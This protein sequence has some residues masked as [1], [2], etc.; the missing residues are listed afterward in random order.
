M[1][2]LSWLR[3]EKP[4]HE[5]LAEEGG[6]TTLAPEPE[7]H[8]TRP[9]WGEVGIH[10]VHRPRRWDVVATAEAPDLPGSRLQFV[11]LPDGSL[12]V[13]D[14]VGDADLAP[15]A[16]AVETQLA[17]PYRVEAARQN[18]DVWAVAARRIEVVDLEQDVDGDELELAF[19]DGQRSL[20][21]DGRPAF[22]SLAALERIAGERSEEYV[23][24]GTRLDGDL[25]EISIAPL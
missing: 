4:L 16:D 2:W 3:R 25:W 23:V 22:G 11:V 20:H 14:Q 10:G 24:R 21:V 9:R 13:D 17:P 12:L 19:S 18:T 6:L 8:D 5:R 15:L 7:P 1:G